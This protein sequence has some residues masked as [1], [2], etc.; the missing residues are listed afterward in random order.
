M[1]ITEMIA[2][3]EAIKE[4]NGDLRLL[5]GNFNNSYGANPIDVVSVDVAV[6]MQNQFAVISCRPIS[7]LEI[8][9]KFIRQ[10]KTIEH[11][12]DTYLSPTRK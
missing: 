12:I 3:L 7:A 6:L 11:V 8:S 5:A 9:E 10:E 2:H 4:K 1:L